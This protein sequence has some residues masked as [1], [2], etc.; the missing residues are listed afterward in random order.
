MHPIY[1]LY[2]KNIPISSKKYFGGNWVP[3][4]SPS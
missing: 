2:A 3:S 1:A 4:L